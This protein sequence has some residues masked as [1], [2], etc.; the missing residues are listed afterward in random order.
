[1]IPGNQNRRD[2]PSDHKVCYS[3]NRSRA[4]EAR[5]DELL[6]ID[7]FP[8]IG[9]TLVRNHFYQ[10]SPHVA[11]LPEHIWSSIPEVADIELA[12]QAQLVAISEFKR[13]CS[14]EA[15][16][17]TNPGSSAPRFY[18]ANGVFKSVDA[19]I[20]HCFVR[21]LHPKRVVEVGGGY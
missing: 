2:V 20:V 17:S 14:S 13:R 1:L 3:S 21:N 12:D 10:P 6:F 18:L 5:A 15:A 8:K 11:E 4:V 19:E 7:E 9:G 16:Y